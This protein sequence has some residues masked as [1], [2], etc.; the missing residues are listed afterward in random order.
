MEPVDFHLYKECFDEQNLYLEV[1][2]S[3]STIK[4]I[5]PIGVAFGVA[6]KISALEETAKRCAA[7]TDADIAETANA[8][9]D[10]RI[11]NM[12]DQ[13]T[14]MMGVLTYG[15]VHDPREDQV[16]SGIEDMTRERDQCVEALQLAED[17]EMGRL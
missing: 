8:E 7:R 5:F 2:L 4:L 14:Q 15:S 16:R 6:R 10:H 13:I 11:E 3:D 12:H 1:N 17:V 9:V